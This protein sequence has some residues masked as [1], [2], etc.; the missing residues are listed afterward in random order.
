MQGHLKVMENVPNII[1]NCSNKLVPIW[2]DLILIYAF[3]SL[4]CFTHLALDFE[5]GLISEKKNPS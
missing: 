4:C 5:N 2:D 1:W 3:C